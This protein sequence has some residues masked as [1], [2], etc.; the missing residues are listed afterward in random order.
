[1]AQTVFR[2]YLEIYGDLENMTWLVAS[3]PRRSSIGVPGG[4]WW[5]KG[6][7]GALIAASVGCS[8]APEAAPHAGPHAAPLAGA[9]DGA[10]P[11]TEEAPAPLAST[12]G[13]AVT[14]PR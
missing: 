4:A 11:P 2:A 3:P 5:K 7:L 13:V 8:A 9:P 14:P 12:V 1:L 6:A 10:L